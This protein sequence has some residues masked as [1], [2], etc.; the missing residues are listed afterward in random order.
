MSVYNQQLIYL[1]SNFVSSDIITRRKPLQ[2]KSSLKG[3]YAYNW[4][5][6][7]FHL[8]S[9]FFSLKTTRNLMTQY[10]SSSGKVI[11][12]SSSR[13]LQVWN[14]F[15]WIDR[16]NL[17]LKWTRNQN[18]TTFKNR[19]ANSFI[20]WLKKWRNRFTRINFCFELK[21]ETDCISSSGLTCPIF[22]PARPMCSWNGR[23]LV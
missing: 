8:A 11:L 7:V 15:C 14:L 13:S 3:F 23:R 10:F 18:Q 22:G 19:D 4:V 16:L 5:Y 6:R 2:L 17:C 21:I 12:Y 20:I 9:F 1:E